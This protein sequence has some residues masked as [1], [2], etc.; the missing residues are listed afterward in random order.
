MRGGF[1]REAKDRIIY[2]V[3][4]L[5][6]CVQCW[7]RRISLGQ[8]EGHHSLRD[9]TEGEGMETCIDRFIDER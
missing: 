4:V 5:R 9:R 1:R 7:G 6:G 2:G 8:E 3:R